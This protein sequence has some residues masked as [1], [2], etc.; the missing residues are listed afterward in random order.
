MQFDAA[1]LT[2]AGERAGLRVRSLTSHSLPEGTAESIRT[3]LRRRCAV[4]KR[5]SAKIGLIDHYLAPRY[6]RR[7]DAQGRGEALL[8]TFEHGS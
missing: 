2:R 1:S 5:L 4:P 3:I 7:N 6:A 8:V